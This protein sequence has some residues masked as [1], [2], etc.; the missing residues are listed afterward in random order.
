MRRPNSMPE[1][2]FKRTV[3]FHITE[4]GFRGKFAGGAGVG[5]RRDNPGFYASIGEWI[6]REMDAEALV[7]QWYMPDDKKEEQGS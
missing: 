3:W 7:D 6:C 2:S 5:I 4:I 1:G